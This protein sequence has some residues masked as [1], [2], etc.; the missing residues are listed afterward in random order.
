MAFVPALVPLV[1]TAGKIVRNSSSDER[2]NKDLKS[3]HTR[4]SSIVE[5]MCAGPGSPVSHWSEQHLERMIKTNNVFKEFEDQLRQCHAD[6]RVG[7]SSMG[8]KNE[9]KLSWSK[10]EAK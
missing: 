2:D 6:S 1:F 9:K 10:K 3:S 4:K 5:R 8:S 7:Q